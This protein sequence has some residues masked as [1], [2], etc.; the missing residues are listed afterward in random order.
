M[1]TDLQAAAAG[2]A[3]PA[4]AISR[5]KAFFH[6][7][8]QFAQPTTQAVLTAAGNYAALQLGIASS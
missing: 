4:K 3:E 6:W 5:A 2:T 8:Q 1:A 7:L